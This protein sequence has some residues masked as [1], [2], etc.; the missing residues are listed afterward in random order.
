MKNS[1]NRNSKPIALFL[2]IT[3]ALSAIFYFLIIYS[4]TLRGGNGMYVTGLMWSPGIAA[5]ITMWILKRNLSELGWKWGKSKYQIGSYVIPILYTLAAYLII[6]IVGWGSFYNKGLVG[7]LTQ[8][9]GLGSIGDGFTIALYVILIGIF[10]TIQSAV[11]ALGEEIGWRGFLVPELYKTQGF[12]KTS[13]ITG[14]I[15]GVWHSPILL[16]ADYN[17]GTPVWYAMTCFMVL[18]VSISFIY[19]WF[20]IRSG[21]L[22]TAV[23]LHATHN[24]FIQ[25]IFT[26]LTTNTGNTAYYMDEFG[27]VLPIISIG[28]A[29]YFWSRRKELIGFTI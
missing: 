21:S 9:F 3:L 24:M 22:W 2:S 23:I 27:I 26:P 10:G 8:S 14:L 7:S 6:W 29:I 13:L 15:W 12:T 17:S 28:V 20:R 19:T 18:V 11:T 1:T 16:F 5:L 25:G 4:G